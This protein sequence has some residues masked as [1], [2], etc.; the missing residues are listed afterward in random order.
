MLKNKNAIELSLTVVVVA[1]ILLFTA[2]VLL[3][4]FKGLIG[5]EAEQAHGII[6]DYDGDGILDLVDKCPCDSGISEHSGCPSAAKLEAYE[7][8][9]DT[10]KAELRKCPEKNVKK[11]N[12]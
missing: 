4:I 7:S 2:I 3:T 9:D 10:R 1:A 11:T 5:K 12:S 6:G 8:A